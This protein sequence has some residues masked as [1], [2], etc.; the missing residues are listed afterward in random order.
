MCPAGAGLHRPVRPGR[1]IAAL[2]GQ[3]AP[4]AAGQP[5]AG[6]ASFDSVSA[7]ARPAESPLRPIPTEMG[8]PP[9]PQA[10]PA[11]GRQRAGRRHPPVPAAGHR[12]GTCWRFT[13]PVRPPRGPP[14]RAGRADGGHRPGRT[15]HHRRPEARLPRRPRPL[16]RPRFRLPPPH[17]AGEYEDKRCTRSAG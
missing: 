3:A 2:I 12:N 4:G 15:R 14:R 1:N 10:G 11:A 8:Q 9:S 5:S 6:E 17:P 16:R 13:A 7:P